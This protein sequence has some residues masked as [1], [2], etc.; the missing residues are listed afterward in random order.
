MKRL[1]SP[2]LRG[3]IYLTFV[4]LSLA[5]ILTGIS[6]LTQLGFAVFLS[7]QLITGRFSSGSAFM[8]AVGWGI[9]LVGLVS[10]I[11]QFKVALWQNHLWLGFP[12]AWWWVVFIL[13]AW[14][15]FVVSEVRKRMVR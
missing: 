6:W 3:A 9:V 7:V 8:A 15:G 2:T 14:I 4:T 1:K 13:L 5:P 12:P 11:W 10:G